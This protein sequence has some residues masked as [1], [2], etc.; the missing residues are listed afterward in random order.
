MII[1]AGLDYAFQR[2]SW[3]KRLRMTKDE[4]RR[5]L[6]ETEG[7]PQ[8]KG[9]LR[10]LRDTRARKRMVAAVKDATVLIMNPTHFAV[11]LDYEL[12]AEE[13]PLCL[14]KGVDETALRM[15]AAAEEH[16]VP[17]V[18]NPPLARALYASVEVDEQIPIEHYEAVA[19][20]IGFIMRKAKAAR[21]KS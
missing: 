7:D 8:I 19:G 5:E 15:R 16:G 11:A 1:I 10:Q 20:V 12:G 4:I 21:P 6:K 13:A 3:K 18:E 2:H 9:R 14:A 17:V